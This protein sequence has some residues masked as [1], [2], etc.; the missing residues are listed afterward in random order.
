MR[1]TILRL[2]EKQYAGLKSHLLPGDGREA[3]AVALCVRRSGQ[4]RH[5]LLVRR[6][7]LIPHAECRVREPDLLTWSTERLVPLMQEAM[8]HGMA[9]LKIHSHP[10]GVP[11][12][13]QQD[14]RSDTDLFTSI[15]GWMD[16]PLPHASAVMMPDGRI[17]ARVIEP[18]L[19]F[20]PISMVTVAGTD[21][22]YWFDDER[23]GD[24]IRA[25]SDA[26][27]KNAQVFGS[28][29]TNLL[30]RLSVAV[31][32]CSGTGGPSRNSSDAWR[33]EGWCWW[34]RTGSKRRT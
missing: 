13:S 27:R 17:F 3:V 18:D 1:E 28:R 31:V 25:Y 21:L 14:D 7:E 20:S 22:A 6:I 32:G 16:S 10:S 29:T 2:T 24:L 8:K 30:K 26:D 33:L 12:F 11:I 23:D 5:V 15:Y 34:T 19:D 4:E 9:I